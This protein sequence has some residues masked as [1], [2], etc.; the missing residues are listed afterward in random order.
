[1]V[2]VSVW[3]LKFLWSKI[4]ASLIFVI[5]PLFGLILNFALSWISGHQGDFSPV[6]AALL[7]WLATVIRELITT[8]QVKGIGGSVTVTKGMF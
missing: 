2:F 1:V 5:A 6:L 8:L 4:P 3:G 7:G